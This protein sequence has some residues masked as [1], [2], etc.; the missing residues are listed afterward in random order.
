MSEIA[1]R[2]DGRTYMVACGDGEE[3]QLVKLGEMVDAKLKAMSDN[4]SPQE[5]QNLLFAALHLAD[6]LDETRSGIADRIESLA[7]KLEKTAD[8]LESKLGGP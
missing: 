3:A 4:L 7:E 2:I 8:N 6:E 1:L 5:S